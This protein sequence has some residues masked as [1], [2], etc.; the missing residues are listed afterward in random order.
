MNF[1]YRILVFFIVTFF[2]NIFLPAQELELPVRIKDLVEVRG[3]RPNQLTGLGLVVG[4]QGTGD[5]K[6][7]I[8]TNRAAA[9]VMN[10]LGMTVTPAEVITKNIAVVVVTAEL[11]PLQE[12]EIK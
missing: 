7:S 4:L 10:R 3:V 6:S 1:L 8:A 2:Y 5:S 12:L 11:P 9:A